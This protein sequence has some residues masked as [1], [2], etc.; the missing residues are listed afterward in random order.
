MEFSSLMLGTVQF[1]MDY[2]IANRAGKPSQAAV[3]E[4]IS[5]AW[6][7]GVNCLDT[8][9]AYGDSE[10][11]VGKALSELNL[12]GK[13]KIISKVAH[14][15]EGITYNEL[16]LYIQD[17][18]ETSLRRLQVDYLDVCLFHHEKYFYAIEILARMKDR[19]LIKSTGISFSGVSFKEVSKVLL[20]SFVDAVQIPGSILDR[21]FEDSG[22]RLA[23]ENTI[24]VFVRS[25]YLQGLLLM[26]TAPLILH[27]MQPALDCIGELSL[28]HHL[29]RE[30]I[31]A[32][33]ML[34]IDGV[35]SLLMGVDNI[36]QL[37]ENINLIA[38]GPLSPEL[39]TEIS[40]SLPLLPERLLSPSL[41]PKE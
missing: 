6:E 36:D 40:N 31:C 38:Q 37:Q 18:V 41:W 16:L 12:Q 13:M 17:S 15:P 24:P 35:S 11:V 20:S 8:A 26:D 19:G 2:G 7:H 30:A 33:Y 23:Q 4:M 39:Q 27:E 34:G 5:Y 9:A 28:Q 10:E 25:T 22:Y 1:G 32:R 21:R 3:C 14:I 29:T